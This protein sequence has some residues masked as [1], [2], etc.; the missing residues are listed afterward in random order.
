MDK[1]EIKEELKMPYEELLLY[2]IKKY[3]G[4]KCDYFANSESKVK[5]YLVQKRAYIV[6]IWMKIKGEI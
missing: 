4:A 6:I 1:H 5:R 2:L 3:G